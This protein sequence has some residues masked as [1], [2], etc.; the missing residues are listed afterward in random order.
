[1]LSSKKYANN[2][3]SLMKK[4]KLIQKYWKKCLII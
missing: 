3:A 1:M 4:V 2:L